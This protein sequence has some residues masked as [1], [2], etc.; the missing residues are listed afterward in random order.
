MSVDT[1]TPPQAGA[2][3]PV[4]AMRQDFVRLGAEFHSTS[5][6]QGLPGPRL[7]MVGVDAAALLGLA[8]PHDDD[9]RQRWA[10]L[11]SGNQAARD[12]SAISTVYA[13]HQFG[14][15]A[16]QLGDGRAHLLGEARSRDARQ[17][18]GHAWWEVQIKGAGPTPF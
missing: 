15:W 7:R 2:A 12:A 8:P 17:A 13:G 18:M 10:D 16:G 5:P 14:N 9:A 1:L 11:F 4:L 6:P 3:Q